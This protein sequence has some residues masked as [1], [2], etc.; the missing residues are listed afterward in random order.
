MGRAGSALQG[1]RSPGP[2]LISHDRNQH[3]D[4]DTMRAALL[5]EPGRLESSELPEP[6]VPGPGEALVAVRR[7]GI[8]G[9]D[10]HAYSGQQNFFAYP[11]VLGHE[12]DVVAQLID[13]LWGT[14]AY[15]SRGYTFVSSRELQRR[16][17]KWDPELPGNFM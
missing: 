12:R 11:R 1:M 6:P 14:H 7:V 8:C 13:P 17:G 2:V 5:R 16:R 10:F 3:K 15:D 9:T 4:V